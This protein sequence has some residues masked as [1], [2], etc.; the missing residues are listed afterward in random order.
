M[1]VPMECDAGLA[2]E[3]LVNGCETMKEMLTGL[4]DSQGEGG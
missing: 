3:R 1:N 4:L 2:R